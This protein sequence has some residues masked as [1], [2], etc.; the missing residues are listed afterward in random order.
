MI[1]TKHLSADKPTSQTYPFPPPQLSLV[2]VETARQA[3]RQIDDTYKH[4]A[5]LRADLYTDIQYIH[6]VYLSLLYS[7]LPPS[8]EVQQTGSVGGQQSEDADDQPGA[9]G[10]GKPHY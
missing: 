8:P 4:T 5:P 7:W 9:L 6:N 1:V 3:E 10:L 2:T